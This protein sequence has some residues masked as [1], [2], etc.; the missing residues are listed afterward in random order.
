MTW[1]GQK[2]EP[3]P[4][5]PIRPTAA[6]SPQAAPEPMRAVRGETM[7]TSKV[8]SIGKSLH[9]K[10]ELSG[11]EDLVIEG[12]VEG[13]I[14]LNGHSVTIAQTGRVAAEIQAKSVVVGGQV[15]GNITAEERVEVAATGA[16]VG[17]VRSPRVV[18]ADGARFKGSVDM[19]GKVVAGTS[20]AVPATSRAVA[21]PS[22]LPEDTPAYASSTKI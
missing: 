2:Q 5:L 15:K 4:S 22:F 8:A 19:D 6:A 13:K 9:V 10:G 12:S 11:N 1:L 14:T 20:V 21:T 3:E 18:L 7:E 17:D 16:M